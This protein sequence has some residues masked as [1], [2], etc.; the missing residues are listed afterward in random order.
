LVQPEL[1]ATLSQIAEGGADAFYTGPIAEKIVAEMRRGGGL[2]TA[3]DLAKYEA[4]ERRPV[5]IA[6]RGYDIYAPPL[7]SSGGI[8]LAQMLGMLE[9]FD[10]AKQGRWSPDTLHVMVEAMRRA[11]CD[12]ARFLGDSDFV[13][14]PDHLT[15]KE[16]SSKLAAAIDVRRATRSE[17]LAPEIALA[18]EK[19]QTTHFSIVDPNGMA[20]SNTYTLEDRY[21][22]RIVVRGAGFLLNNEMGDFNWRPGVT[23][24]RGAIGTEANTIAPGKR[25]LSSMTPVIVARDGKPVLL[26]GSPGGRTIINTVMQVIVNVIDFEMP[27]AEAVSA[28]RIHQG[29]FPDEIR[30]EDAA[31]A[32]HAAVIEELKRRGHRFAG[33]SSRQGDA[34]SIRIGK[35]RLEG[36]A[37]GRIS[38]H[39]A[40]F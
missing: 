23:N 36:A 32:K 21:G 15:S 12:R 7:P 14:I 6:Y 29:W 3:D 28:P 34:H 8:G 17:D 24:R 26:T 2:I 5:R 1:A 35:G 4:R 27:L 11:Y 13:K 37:D 10:L 20:V 31:N 19:E 39:A 9:R 33:Q 25:M 18:G 16:Y 38:G 22:S 30:F 40:G